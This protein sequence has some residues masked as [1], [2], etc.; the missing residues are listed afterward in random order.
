[1]GSSILDVNNNGQVRFA[2]RG[3]E[4]VGVSLT[5][6]YEVPAPLAP[7]ASVESLFCCCFL[8]GWGVLFSGDREREAPPVLRAPLS[9]IAENLLPRP[10][11]SHT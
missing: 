1:M 8:G 7:F 11:P 4:S 3:A 6:S 5:I 9:P 2:R 10:C